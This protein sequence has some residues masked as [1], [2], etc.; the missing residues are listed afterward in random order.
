VTILNVLPDPVWEEMLSS[1]LSGIWSQDLYQIRGL[2][3]A[4]MHQHHP[5][6]EHHPIPAGL[7]FAPL[8]L[9]IREE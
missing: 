9:A 7:H 8:M 3:S 5:T 2:G 1:L 6:P 4:H